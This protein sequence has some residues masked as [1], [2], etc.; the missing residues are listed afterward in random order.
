MSD[1][2]DGSPFAR[3]NGTG[4]SFAD[5]PPGAGRIA[6]T[7][8]PPVSPDDYARFAGPP[9]TD[10]PFAP[11]AGDR[12]PPLHARMRQPVPSPLVDSFG[13]DGSGR[14]FDA[15]PGTRLTATKPG[16]G[17]PWWKE[18]AETDP[19]RDPLS[20]YWL[21]G[22]PVFVDGDAVGIGEPAED[23]EETKTDTKRGEGS[24][25]RFGLSAL[26]IVLVAGLIAGVVGGG[27][28]WWVSERAHR[29]LT[30][31]N[32]KIAQVE[33]PASRPV[34]SVAEIAQRVSPAVVSI[35]VR[36]ADLA[37]SGSGVVIDKG[38][39]ILTNNHVVNF[40][41]E[42]PTIRV[43]FSD[44]S[45]APGRVVGTD[46]QNDLAVIKVDK[47]SLTIASLG[48]SDALAVGDPVVAIG[49]PLG[50]RG[51]VT[52]GIVSA[53]KRPLRLSGE[54]GNPDAVIDAIQTDA[55]IN[56]G[57][58]GGALVDGAGAVV[59]INTA[60]LSLG[61]SANGGQAG[62]IGVGFAI[63]INT[64][65][66]VATQ[67]IRTGK[68]THA[69]MG[70]SS[71]SVTDGSRDGAYLV[72]II[73]GGPADKAGLKEGD[74]VTLFGKTLIDSGDALTVA[75]AESKP[76]TTVKISY[77]RKGVTAQAEVTLGSN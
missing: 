68:V 38:G 41:A 64:A 52:A 51:T 55:P 72:Q 14:P 53:L 74:V 15:A 60:I 35:D 34:G 8:P 76:G 59:G 18:D 9:G 40:G 7:P 27:V 66:D 32:V 25:R 42:K 21:A 23:G 69:T 28:G 37:G 31:P 4:G 57:N 29:I 3:P 61:Q 73:P 43:I 2:T 16:P 11:A 75:V 26:A 13:G 70:V 58:S 49:D 10:V 50:L 19:W 47:T 1:E 63:P 67:L 24:R 33:R 12:L 36:T 56:P 45:S 6:S 22:P 77:V 65:R 17:S 20:P 62:S 5:R 44:K 46:P 39:Y 48:N 54:N 71:R 30:D